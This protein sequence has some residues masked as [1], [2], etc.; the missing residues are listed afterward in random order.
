MKEL[1]WIYKIQPLHSAHLFLGRPAILIWLQLWRKNGYQYFTIS[2]NS[3]LMSTLSNLR[4]KFACLKLQRL[5]GK[6]S[7]RS[8]CEASSTAS[9]LDIEA[10]GNSHDTIIHLHEKRFNSIFAE[11]GF[12]FAMAASQVL[13][14]RIIEPDTCIVYLILVTGI[15]LNRLWP[16]L[17]SYSNWS[18]VHCYSNGL[19]IMH[20]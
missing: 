7:D 16:Y 4:R 8:N 12:C 11:C 20:P 15:P 9:T 10:S 18:Q 6:W 14:V 13:A 19:G 2:H 3:T 1:D 17:W 5:I